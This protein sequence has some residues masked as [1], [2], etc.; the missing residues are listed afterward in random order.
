[1]TSSKADAEDALIAFEAAFE[2]ATTVHDDILAKRHELEEL[3]DKLQADVEDLYA[4]LNE[5]LANG[6]AEM[7]PLNPMT[8][9]SYGTDCTNCAPTLRN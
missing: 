2:A 7:S 3:T 1:M 6:Y 4:R 8:W 9:T 5:M